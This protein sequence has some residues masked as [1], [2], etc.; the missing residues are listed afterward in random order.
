MGN[1]IAAE[2]QTTQVS[3]VD[4]ESIPRKEEEPKMWN[5]RHSEPWQPI[6]PM[7]ANVTDVDGR[8]ILPFFGSNRQRP[9]S[10]DRR[11]VIGQPTQNGFIP[12]MNS[13]VLVPSPQP[14]ILS[15]TSPE[16]PRSNPESWTK[17]ISRF[18]D[19][20]QI[21]SVPPELH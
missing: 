9:S 1:M 12:P 18:P 13:N 5:H 17:F 2:R 20:L 11:T 21:L 10:P 8:E 19:Y 3:V 4:M 6:H 15:T 14:N 7:Q 16:Y